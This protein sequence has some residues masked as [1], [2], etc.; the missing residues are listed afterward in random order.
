MYRKLL[1]VDDDEDDIELLIEAFQQLKLK[2]CYETL[3]SSRTLLEKLKNCA[4]EDLPALLVIDV[5]M[6]A[7]T[8]IEALAAIRRNRATAHLPVCV[9]ST[10]SDP[11]TQ[12]R[13]YDYGIE[14]YIVKPSE[15]RQLLVVALEINRI[16][17]RL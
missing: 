11:V 8:G 10:S 3:T 2:I 5:N 17:N 16:L 4:V 7:I 9:M 1:I 12:Q 15:Y 14:K 13:C 6:P